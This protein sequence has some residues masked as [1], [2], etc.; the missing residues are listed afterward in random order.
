MID[1][2]DA[3]G[4]ELTELDLLA[5]GVLARNAVGE[6]SISALILDSFYLENAS[7][8]DAHSDGSVLLETPI[9]EVVVIADGSHSAEDQ[10]ASWASG[11]GVG[12]FIPVT[13]HGVTRDALEEAGQ[14]WTDIGR[15][16]FVKE[17]SAEERG[18]GGAI[19]ARL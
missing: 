16:V 8:S 7:G 19:N 2:I 18:I 4:D 10:F 17:R 9:K 6:R 15:T 12:F 14:L 3:G 5:V 1:A 13:P 11:Y